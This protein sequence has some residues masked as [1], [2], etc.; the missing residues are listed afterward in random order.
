M[1]TTGVRWI[2]GAKINVNPHIL[3]SLYASDTTGQAYLRRGSRHTD[4]RSQ[5]TRP[6]WMMGSEKEPLA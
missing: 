5:R 2:P 4:D 1:V 6:A 3:E